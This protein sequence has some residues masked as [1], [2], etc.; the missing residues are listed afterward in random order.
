MVYPRVGGGTFSD[1]MY[2]ME[3]VGL[4]PRGRGNRTTIRP[5]IARPGSIPAWAGEPASETRQLSRTRV[6]PR[7]GGGTHG[8]PHPPQFV[9]GLSPRGRGNPV[10]S[11][12][13]G[14]EIGSIPA[15]AG[16]PFPFVRIFDWMRVYP[17]VGGGTSRLMPVNYNASGLSPRGRGN[18][19]AIEHGMC[20]DWSIPAWAGE[21]AADSLAHVPGGVYPRVGGGTPI[22]HCVTI[23]PWGLSPRGRGNLVSLAVAETRIGSIPAWA[24]E[25]LQGNRKNPIRLSKSC[26]ACGPACPLQEEGVSPRALHHARQYF[27]EPLRGLPARGHHG[28]RCRPRS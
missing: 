23:A 24:G 20:P 4:S 26:S 19:R 9:G 14:A 5:K 2:E 22:G 10:P 18:P 8:L 17:R 25:P 16:E 3:A 1:E 15:W 13:H 12:A 6:Y 7:V 27:W 28:N 11:A 21:P